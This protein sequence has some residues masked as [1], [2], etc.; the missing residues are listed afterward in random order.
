MAGIWNNLG[1]VFLKQGD[2][3][4]A[5]NHFRR[6]VDLDSG[7]AEAYTNLALALERQGEYENA[8]EALQQLVAIRPD[9][10]HGWRH[11][12]LMRLNRGQLAAAAEAIWQGLAIDPDFDDIDRI[13][14][15][16]LQAGIY[17]GLCSQKAA[18]IWI[19]RLRDLDPKSP[20]PDLLDYGLCS[21]TPHTARAAWQKTASRLALTLTRVEWGE[22]YGRQKSCSSR[23]PANF[24]VLLN[25]GRSGT[26][27][28][29]SLLDGHP[30]VSTMPGIYLK[31]FFSR[32][33]WE[34]VADSDPTV[35]AENFCALYEVLF[36][37]RIPKNVPGNN[38]SANYPIGESE[39]FTRMGEHGD[40]ALGLDRDRFRC[41]LTDRLQG[42]KSLDSGRFFVHVHAAFEQVLSRPWP[43]DL[44]FYHI[45]N[46]GHFT[47]INFLR[48]FPGCRI[49]MIVRHPLQSLESWISKKIDEPGAYPEIVNRVVR[50]LFALDRP[51]FDLFPAAGVR[52]EDLKQNPDATLKRI[53]RFLGIDM[54]PSL[55]QSTMQGIRWWGDPGS[56]RLD[57]KGPFGQMPNDP[58]ARKI[59]S[60]LSERD[61]L[62]L[63][64]LF[65]P[66]N[67]RFGYSFEDAATFKRNLHRIRTLLDQPFDFELRYSKAF[68]M[69]LEPLE[70]NLFCG[71]LRRMLIHRW[72]TL[73]AS[74][75]Y[76]G[77]LR[78]I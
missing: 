20:L 32:G 11:L 71:Y 50:M 39:G 60:I 22:G 49:L 40:E 66:L 24:A 31:D 10:G 9:H 25:F 45:H 52:L 59:G 4:Q 29:H 48:Q 8:A 34:A 67:L 62:V 73:V 61:Q 14:L 42:E 58:T 26:G 36:D 17:L 3:Q 19:A 74:G 13:L 78:P 77:L 37:A 5:A 53:C 27:F 18:G 76:P 72:Q 2:A 54:A 46:P 12:G 21:L 28:L 63:E 16:L 23:G 68:P 41:Y 33:V 69:D 38:D 57:K 47:F 7:F 43:P 56:V 44:L 51:E 65:S 70:Q 1:V 6:A 55:R 64:T 30:R 35:M 15:I 75:T